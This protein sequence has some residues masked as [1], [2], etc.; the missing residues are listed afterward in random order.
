MRP[1]ASVIATG[2]CC[3]ACGHVNLRILH[4]IDQYAIAQCPRCLLART[5]GASVEPATF[6]DG[7]YFAGGDCSKGYSDYFA[8]AD[9][10]Q[11]TFRARIR[12]LRRSAPSAHT[13]LDAGCGPGFFVREA[14]RHGFD[15][16]GLEVSEYAVRCGVKDLGQRIVQGPIDAAHLDE[17][18]GPFD[19]ITLWDTIEHLPAPDEALQALSGRLRP[20]GI[21]ALST[22]DVTS[23]AAR[24][25]GPRWHLFNLPE[26]LWFFSVPSLKR[27][28]HRAGLTVERVEREIC[29]YTAQYLLERLL[30]SFG[31]RSGRLP[32]VATLRRV[33]VPVTL[34]DIVTVYARRPRSV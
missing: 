16:C 4:R 6:Y 23:L 19:I 31:R 29:W 34:L 9:A 21:L 24:A 22:G 14:S 18:G 26:H 32:A 27:L 15:A 33:Q 28:L 13:L 10:I 5:L 2:E 8:L 3:I 30:F 7:S 12:R 20:D 25:A 11:R 1:T 17:A